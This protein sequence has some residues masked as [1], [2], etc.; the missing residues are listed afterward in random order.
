MTRTHFLTASMVG[1][2][3]VASVAQADEEGTSAPPAAATPRLARDS[4]VN[5]AMPN[6]VPDEFGRVAAPNPP[7]GPYVEIPAVRVEHP[8]VIVRQRVEIYGAPRIDAV[9]LTASSTAPASNLMGAVLVEP[10]HQPL[11]PET[12]VRAEPAATA[13]SAVETTPAVATTTPTATPAT[14][15]ATTRD[16]SEHPTA[17]ATPRERLFIERSPRARITSL[18]EAPPASTLTRIETNERRT[19]GVADSRLP[20]GRAIANLTEDACLRVLREQHVA[21]ER[22]DGAEAV[23][24]RTPIRV[25]G[26]LAGIQ[27]ETRES[28][29]ELHSIM[30]CR[31]AVAIL[32]WAPALHAANVQRI[33]H[34]SIYRPHAVV[35]GTNTRS[36]HASAMAF[37]SAVYHFSDGTRADVLTGWGD[38][39]RGDDP[40][41][42]YDGETDQAKAMRRAVCSAI[43]DEIFEIVLT[44]HYDRAHQNHVHLELRPDVN[45]AFIH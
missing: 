40:C 4:D 23:G 43:H 14:P 38:R 15:T 45:W 44:P 39:T 1:I 31:M 19:D 7:P 26:A 35:A 36:G 33:D 3:L 8:T 34:Y 2:T 13:T 29:D 24:V 5:W 11:V 21:Y 12:V 9:P 20:R 22:V 32:A 17:N 30:D 25:R 10:T 37:D 42:E 6:V 28:G 18:T 27:I 41:G 16:A